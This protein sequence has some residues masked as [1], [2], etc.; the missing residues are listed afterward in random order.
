MGFIVNLVKFSHFTVL[1]IA[2]Q[3]TQSRYT[4]GSF[5]IDEPLPSASATNVRVYKV[6][7]PQGP[8][9][10]KFGFDTGEDSD[11]RHFREES[12]DSNGTVRGKYGLVDQWGRYRIT[13]Y[14]SDLDGFRIVKNYFAEQDQVHASNSVHEHFE[15]PDR[16]A[17]HLELETAVNSDTIETETVTENSS[18][19]DVGREASTTGIFKPEVDI[20]ADEKPLPVI[21]GNDNEFQ[22]RAPENSLPW[23]PET[24]DS[25]TEAPVLSFVTTTESPTTEPPATRAPFIGPL[26]P[27]GERRNRYRQKFLTPKYISKPSRSREHSKDYPDS[28]LSESTIKAVTVKPLPRRDHQRS[29]DQWS[30]S[31]PYYHGQQLPFLIYY[32]PRSFDYGNFW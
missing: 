3:G 5:G 26:L 1:L 30:T 4:Y 15:L 8:D 20:V 13:E 9:T 6:H 21:L 29:R 25:Q 7:E 19:N 2:I 31:S 23:L 22:T 14:V 18:L 11:S 28:D 16:P 17:G 27:P 24:E 32:F 10:Y 12:R